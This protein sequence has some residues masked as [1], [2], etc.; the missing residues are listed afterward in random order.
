MLRKKLIAS[1]LNDQ[2]RSD[3]ESLKLDQKSYKTTQLQDSKYFD[4]FRM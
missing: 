4:T 3:S 2:V 1:F